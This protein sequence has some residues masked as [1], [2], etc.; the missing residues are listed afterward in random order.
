MEFKIQNLSERGVAE[1][2]IE[3]FGL[4]TNDSRLSS[5]SLIFI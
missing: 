2:E 5:G 4:G 1:L 3:I